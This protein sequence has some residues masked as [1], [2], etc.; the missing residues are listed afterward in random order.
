MVRRRSPNYYT[1]HLTQNPPP[2]LKLVRAT[3]Y[4]VFFLLVMHP[5]YLQQGKALKTGN[6][7]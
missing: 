7:I 6:D 2:S 1:V 4:R 3:I 5:S